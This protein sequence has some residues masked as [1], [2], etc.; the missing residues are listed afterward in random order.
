MSKRSLR[1]EAKSLIESVLEKYKVSVSCRPDISAD[2]ASEIFGLLDVPYKVQDQPRVIQGSISIKPDGERDYRVAWEI[3]VLATG[4]VDAAKK[5][6]AIMVDPGDA[7]VFNV[8]GENIDLM[9]EI[10]EEQ[11]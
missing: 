5:A 7:I 9:E 2:I 1:D 4:K 6:M 11:G 10:V 8:E 3:D